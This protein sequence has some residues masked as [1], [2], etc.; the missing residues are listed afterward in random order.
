MEEL[1]PNLSKQQLT[2]L[3]LWLDCIEHNMMLDIGYLDLL[4]KQLPIGA[5]MLQMRLRIAKVLLS[6]ALWRIAVTRQE[7]R[8]HLEKK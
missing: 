7:A 1:K 3:L 4:L 8:G 2:G 5:L 6:G